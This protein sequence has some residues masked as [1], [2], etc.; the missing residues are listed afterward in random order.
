MNGF[1]VS[2]IVVIPNKKA[3]KES[4]KDFVFFKDDE[5]PFLS[6]VLCFSTIKWLMS[7]KKDLESKK[8]IQKTF[9]EKYS[10][11]KRIFSSNLL[12]STSPIAWFATSIEQIKDL[13]KNGFKA[14]KELR[15]IMEIF[16]I[17]IFMFRNN[18]SKKT[19]LKYIKDNYGFD[20][21]QVN[22]NDMKIC[23]ILKTAINFVLLANDYVDAMSRCLYIDTCSSSLV[24]L[25][26]ILAEAYFQEVPLELIK[27]S[28]EILPKYLK[29]LNTRFNRLLLDKI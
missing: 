11:Q 24:Y 23:A 7:N 2:N 1:L 27:R 16:N 8:E 4:S 12:I 13:L 14:T 19:Y 5:E 28:R 9:I 3:A 25:T 6:T 26:S 10:K 22:E 21:K 17:T 29:D 20:V 15:N 18:I